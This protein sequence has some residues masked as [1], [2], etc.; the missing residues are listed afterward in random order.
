MIYTYLFTLFIIMY[1]INIARRL[2]KFLI[3]Q[4]LHRKIK[5]LLDNI[6]KNPYEFEDTSTPNRFRDMMYNLAPYVNHYLR[7]ASISHKNKLISNFESLVDIFNHLKDLIPY[8]RR[9]LMRSL[10]P[11]ISITEI[12][13]IILNAPVNLFLAL[14]PSFKLS[15]VWKIFISLLI[16]LVGIAIS[17]FNSNIRQFI[18]DIFSGVSKTK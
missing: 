3:T 10:N 18:V 5:Y 9:D 8:Y 12:L 2:Y 15:Q 4:K 11:I 7:S 1:V 16:W 17:M 6:S 14:F 13:S